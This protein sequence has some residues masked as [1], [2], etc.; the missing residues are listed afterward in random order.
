MDWHFWLEHLVQMP[1]DRFPFAVFV[2]RQ[3]EVFG[4]LDRILQFA[5]LLLFL[6][7]NDVH[8]LK[9]L[10]GIHPQIG[11]RFRLELLRDLFL[12]LRQISNVANASL[13]LIV[14]SQV[15]RNRLRFGWRLDD[16]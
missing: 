1:R 15:F 9:P 13:D 2:R 16:H 3:I 10:V 6:R 4:L 11:P 12:S 8:R 14:A 5:D 7:W